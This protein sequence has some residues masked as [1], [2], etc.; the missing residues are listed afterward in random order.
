MYSNP[1]KAVIFWICLLIILAGFASCIHADSGVILT[2]T[3]TSTPVVYKM[4]MFK[5]AVHKNEFG[6]MAP[7]VS[8]DLYKILG[9][10]VY[11]S[12]CTTDTCYIFTN[13]P[14]DVNEM[15]LAF[16]YQLLPLSK[17]EEAT[18]SELISATKDE[19]TILNNGGSR[20]LVYEEPTETSV[21]K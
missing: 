5:C 17:E 20:R 18:Y 12:R 1:A 21:K 11:Y 2:P 14:Q 3:Y 13:I 4:V 6:V 15:L 19:L 16:Q 9:L 10:N 8:S 7:N